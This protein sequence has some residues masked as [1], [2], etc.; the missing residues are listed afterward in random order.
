MS[1]KAREFWIRPESTPGEYDIIWFRK[2][3]CFAIHVIEKSAYDQLKAERDE[4][5]SKIEALECICP[6]CDKKAEKILEIYDGHKVYT[7]KCDNCGFTW[8]PSIQEYIIDYRN[9][10]KMREERDRLAEVNKVLVEA[11]EWLVIDVQDY[12]TWQRPCAAVTNAQAALTKAKE[13]S[14]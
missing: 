1:E 6:S 14:K 12:E 3:R 8:L 7:L 4:L 2:P 11:L 10:K 5:K 13:M 9:L